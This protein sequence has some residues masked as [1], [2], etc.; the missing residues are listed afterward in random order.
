MMVVTGMAGGAWAHGST[1]LRDGWAALAHRLGAAA[2]A[3]AL[4]LGVGFCAA[5]L[6][7]VTF[8]VPLVLYTLL[9]IYT[10]AAVVIGGHLADRGGH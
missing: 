7:P 9:F 10:M 2:I 4:L 6:S 3:G 8:M 1:S 5:A